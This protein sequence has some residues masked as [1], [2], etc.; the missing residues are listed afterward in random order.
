MLAHF[1]PADTYNAEATVPELRRAARD[2]KD[3][4][5]SAR[6][7]L[8]FGWG[9]GGGGPTAQMLETFARVGDLQDVPRT[10][11]GHP[12]AFFAGAGRRGAGGPRWWA[13]S[14]SEYRRG[15]YTTQ[16]RTKRASRRA[17][18]ALHD[19]ELL[20]AVRRCAVGRARSSTARGCT[21]LLN[22]FHDILPGSSIGEVTRACRA[23]PG[24]GRG[25]RRRRP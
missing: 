12:E 10:A 1:P 18:R 24:R 20:A 19:A 3:H 4:A 15:T 22:H 8:V 11:I 5:L 17:E 21:L 2:F 9:D 6:S 16:A 7:L 13:S 23:R 14:T 25:D